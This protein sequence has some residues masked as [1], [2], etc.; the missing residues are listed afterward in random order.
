MTYYFYVTQDGKDSDRQAVYCIYP[1]S[2][3][4]K[5]G[6]GVFKTVVVIYST[7][8]VVKGAVRWVYISYLAIKGA[9]VIKLEDKK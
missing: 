3:L 7:Y 4:D 2:T 6:K 8:F 5:R 1:F 9:V